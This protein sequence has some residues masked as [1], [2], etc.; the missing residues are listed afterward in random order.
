MDKLRIVGGRPISGTIRVGGAKNA[1]LPL[2]AA[3]LLSEEPITLS[4][5][6]YLRDITTMAKLLA[7]HGVHVMMHEP[8]DQGRTITLDAGQIPNLTAPYD[9]VRTMRASVLVLGPLLGRFGRAR[10]SLPGGCAIGSRPIDLHL[11]ALEQMGADITLEEGYVDA[12]TKDGLKGAD[13][14]FEQVSVGATENILM[15]ASLADGTTILRNAAQEPEIGDL[16]NLLNAMG[17]DITGI[18]SNTLTI[19][20][21]KS[22]KGAS[23][24]VIADR[25]ETGSY[26]CMI[27]LTGGEVLLQNAQAYTSGALIQVLNNVGVAIEET[28]LGIKVTKKDGPLQPANIVTDPYPGFPTDMQA[29]IMALLSMADGESHITETIFENRY[30]HVP[31]LTRMGANIAIDRRMAHIKGVNELRGAEVMATDLRAS[32]CLAIAAL[33]AKGETVIHRVY[34]LDRGYERLEE[35]LAACGAEIER[36]E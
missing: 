3:C 1:A 22:L 8:N 13:I 21:V 32:V 23:H 10:V 2:M 12:R 25:I 26:L 29:Q 6:P 34:H 14:T 9:I 11:K 5:I 24:R 15:A 35:K 30:M 27:G 33:A 20:G 16:A 4:N 36:V 7:Q 17:A 28:D 18:D 31:E 19:K